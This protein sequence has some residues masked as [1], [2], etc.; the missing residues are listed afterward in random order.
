MSRHG[1]IGRALEWAVVGR[2]CRGETASGDQHLVAPFEG[3]VLLAVIDALGHGPRAH[4][5]A[6]AAVAALAEAPGAPVHALFARCDVALKRLRG[7]V[8]SLASIH[9]GDGL[10]RWAGVGNVEGALLGATGRVRLLGRGG[11]VGQ[12]AVPARAAAVPL[13]AGDVLVLATDGVAASCVEGMDRA[14]PVGWLASNA[15]ERHAVGRD[16]ALILTARVHGRTP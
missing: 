4:L 9:F 12:G 8:M 2:P 16:D 10:M 3:G 6:E 5:T 14:A 11:V 7:A 15:I 13:S 1:N